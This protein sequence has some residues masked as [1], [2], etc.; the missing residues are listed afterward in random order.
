MTSTGTKKPRGKPFVKGEDPRR[1]HGQSG[2]RQ[3]MPIGGHDVP[4]EIT[5]T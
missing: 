2:H 4:P 5:T 3:R 1:V